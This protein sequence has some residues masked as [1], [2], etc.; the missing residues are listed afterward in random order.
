MK[1][2]TGLAASALVAIVNAAVEDVWL[3]ESSRVAP[4]SDAGISSAIICLKSGL[5][6]GGIL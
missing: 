6:L 5:V 2:I 4:S 3:P 1:T